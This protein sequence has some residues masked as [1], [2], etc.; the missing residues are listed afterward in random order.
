MKLDLVYEIGTEEIP[1]GY[2]PPALEQLREE[3]A[4]FLAEKSLPV[5]RIETHATPRRLVL[6]AEGLPER[7]ED[8]REEVTGPPWRAAFDA[9]GRP[10]KA[11][12]GFARGRGIGVGHL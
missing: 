3:F 12:E 6:F 4:G 9:D 1:A 2:L 8:R 11:A 7:Q 5:A 10:T